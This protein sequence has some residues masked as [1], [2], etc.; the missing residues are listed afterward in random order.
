MAFT[1]Y[2]SERTALGGVL[3]DHYNTRFV[4]SCISLAFLSC[5][6]ELFR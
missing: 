1:G 4:V 3:A 6:L 2:G 5:S